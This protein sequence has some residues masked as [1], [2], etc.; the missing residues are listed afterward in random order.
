[1]SRDFT[2]TTFGVCFQNWRIPNRR[3]RT[4]LLACTAIAGLAA[5]PAQ[6]QHIWV[7]FV[8]NDWMSAVNWTSA[9]LPDA[10][11]DVV[12]NTYDNAP[13]ISGGAFA[14][15]ATV[16]IGGVSYPSVLTV[17]DASILFT[18]GG[19][20]FLGLGIGEEGHLNIESG[21]T[22]NSNDNVFIGFNGEGRL[23]IAD[24]TSSVL[25]AYLGMNPEGNGVAQLSNAT[26]SASSGQMV[27]GAYGEGSLVANN[28]S[29]VNSLEGTVAGFDGSLGVVSLANGSAWN[30][31]ILYVGRRGEGYL[32]VLLGS[33][34]T[35]GEAGIIGAA[36]DAYGQARVDGAGSTWSATNVIAVGYGATGQ[37]QV[38]NQGQVN[39]GHVYVGTEDGGH[40]WVFVDSQ[41]H[42]SV[43][44]QLRAG[45][46]GVGRVFVEDGGTMSSA[47]AT[48]G[49]FES[50]EGSIVVGEPGSGWTNT[51][52]LVL[53]DFGD[54][55]LT[56]ANG[57]GMTNTGSTTLGLSPEG[58]GSLA[59]DNATFTT[60]DGLTVGGAG[61]GVMTVI[62]GGTVTSAQN[63]GDAWIG[64]GGTGEVVIS[65]TGSSW[66]NHGE[67]F[68]GSMDIGG[69][70]G[71]GS[72]LVTD[73][74][75]FTNNGIA[76]IGHDS[77]STGQ[78]IVSGGTW[79]NTSSL[80]V[81]N[82][83]NG[84]LVIEDGGSVTATNATI[85]AVDGS[86][87]AVVA[88][89]TGT[90]WSNS[91]SLAIG[92]A[93]EAELA[94]GSGAIVSAQGTITA[95]FLP[96]S[97]AMA[98][99][100]GVLAGLGG[101]TFNTGSHLSGAGTVSA[102]AAGTTTMNGTVAPGN[103]I[104]TLSIFGN[105]V[106]NAGSTYEVE[107]DAAGNSDLIDVSGMAT[108]NG[109]EVVVVPFPNVALATPYTIL[110]AAGGVNGQFDPVAGS[111]SYFLSPELSYD[112]NNVYLTIQ[113]SATFESAAMTPNQIA[114]AQ[115]ADSLPTSNPVWTAI[116]MLPDAPSAQF[117]FDQLSGEIHASAQ[118]AFL[119]DSRF[120]REAALDRLRNALGG[121]G[122]TSGLAEQEMEGGATLW[123]RG[124]GSWSHWDS[125]GNAAMLS[126]NIGGLFVGGDSELFDNVRFGLM[127]G[128]SRSSLNVSD[129]ASSGTVDSFTLGTYV[130]GAWDAFSLKGGLAYG[131]HNLDTSR[132]P[133]FTGFSDS[134]SA[135]YNTRTFQA[136]AE[137]AYTVDYGAVRIEPFANLAYVN[138]SSDA[139]TET[140]GAAALTAL[141]QSA[142]A[143]F[144]TLGLRGETQVDLGGIATTLSGGIGW[145]H[146]FG[147]APTSTHSFAGGNAFTVAGVPLARDT[148]VLDAGVEIDLTDNATFGLS[149]SGQVGSSLSDHGVRASLAVQF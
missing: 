30:T 29:T 15:A 76:Y 148:L 112:L 53:G 60:T 91:G 45:I 8:D 57:A 138:L 18:S 75:Q 133:T 51:G 136:Y 43:T 121:A 86:H 27:V 146:A 68:V 4:L 130:G 139:F 63:S 114:T 125:D 79:T 23:N 109:G 99:V 12:I 69:N 85:G 145:R 56:V 104:G 89:G 102:G 123:A 105:Y 72:L 48:V 98:T 124:F 115:G 20:S 111:V 94:I 134:L 78:A 71:Q 70:L 52:A 147:D 16:T 95:A 1:M 149:Y 81:G 101:V 50:G 119:E 26:W 73:G 2:A 100:N 35:T 49:L 116:A 10:S 117:A 41:G 103:S 84:S 5:L 129:R 74:A 126:R 44:G 87:G 46:D 142:N 34:V 106:Q 14:T 28:S 82:E 22:W 3:R 59:V 31:D 62:L 113:Q 7:G 61:A 127:G 6:A 19:P 110:T 93:G 67:L 11:S 77:G 58:F 21:S 88:N 132:S 9:A 39:A 128:Y 25:S 24:S 131:W 90:V 38:Q 64:F 42:L 144:T 122:Q 13:I 118:T 96:T 32:D 36:G 108:L 141:G 65:D 135:S 137:A 55:R 83:G 120:A 66:T 97:S 140:G 17:T 33:T 37:L 47:G 92:G 80:Y 54:G 40:G 143:T 107:I